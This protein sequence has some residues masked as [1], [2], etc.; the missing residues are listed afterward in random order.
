MNRSVDGLSGS[1]VRGSS[2]RHHATSLVVRAG[3]LILLGLLA[4]RASDLTAGGS[5]DSDGAKGRSESNL[6]YGRP[7]KVFSSHEADG[8]S[9]SKLTD[10]QSGGLG[11]S[12]KAFAAYPD[13]RLYPEFVV[14]DLGRNC[15]LRRVVLYPRGDGA[16]AGKGFPKDFTVQVCR[17]GE[18]W[19]VVVEKRDFPAP[20]DGK[21]QSLA[22]AQAE[23]RYLK[24]EATRLPEVVAGSYRFQLAKIAIFGER[25]ASPALAEKPAAAADG[26]TTVGRLRCEN[27]DN[28]LGIDAQRPR[29]SW[30]MLS[31]ARGQRQTAC[32]VMVA[33]SESLLQRG[34]GDLW[35]SGKLAGDRSIAVA[36]GGRP[37]R[38]SQTYWW[39]VKLWDRDGKETAWSEPAWF[40][41]GKLTPEDWQGQWIGAGPGSPA[42]RPVYLRKEIEVAKPVRRATIFFSGLGFSELYLDGRK[43]GDY[44]IAPGFITYNKRAPYLAFDVTDRFAQTGRKALGVILVDGWYGSGY[45]HGFERNVYVDKPKL[46]LNLHL[47]F[48]DGTETVVVSDGTWKWSDGQIT[49]SS[50][51]Q[52]DIDR[53][54]AQSGWDRAGYDDHGWHA[55][56]V[57]RGPE[58]R[59]V[60]QKEAPCRVVQ[61]IRPASLR[62][63]PQSKTATF[64]FGRELNGWVRFRT[65]GK[66]GT[67]ISITKVPTSRGCHEPAGS[68]WPAPA[69]RKSTS[70]GSTIPACGKWSSRA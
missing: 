6:A 34:Q 43:V 48:A 37:L 66:A 57:V 29:L 31:P 9:V 18:P 53:R 39:K 55:V 13:H 4:G 67:S 25:A 35:D 33:S 64:D 54:R 16:N 38:S 61:E 2:T 62:Y 27:R 22:L 47:E 51:V 68:C 52:E 1:L 45:G 44:V 42:G 8:W 12:S 7:C 32:R 56:A 69:G 23:G 14:V 49:Y 21:A 10:G 50:I 15:T 58:G 63:D 30:W 19:R 36:Y 26:P 24:V 3:I 46:R 59:L 40:L 41:T 11:W 28:P 17:E 20:A 65:S 70:L 60:H 5:T